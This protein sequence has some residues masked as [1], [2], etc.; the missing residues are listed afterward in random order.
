M[1]HVSLEDMG[2]FWTSVLSCAVLMNFIW[3]YVGGKDDLQFSALQSLYMP[4]VQI[5]QANGIFTQKA[6]S[7]TPQK[8]S[9][10]TTSIRNENSFKGYCVFF[11]IF[12]Q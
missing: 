5:S 7:E 6:E 1:S 4:K 10:S 12:A 9:N 11:C 3:F 2:E 8:H